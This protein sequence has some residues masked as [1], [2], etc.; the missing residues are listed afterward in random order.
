MT[1]PAD[2]PTEP[3]SAFRADVHSQHGEDGILAELFDRLASTVE[4]S[5]WC[6]EFGAWDGLHLS[7]TANLILHRG[8]RAVLIEPVAERCA[9]ITR[10]L[11]ADRVNALCASV[12]LDP[13]HRLDDLLVGT[14]VPEDLDLLS[15]DIDGDDL[16]VF[17]T[18]RRH[19]PKVVCIEYNFTIPND[20]HYEQPLG[21][22]VAHGSSASAILEASGPLG[23]VLAAVTDSNLVLVRSDLADAVL[24][25][26]RPTLEELRDD[27]DAR[28]YLFSGYDGTLLT[29]APVELPWHHVSVRPSDLQV[30][31]ARLRRFPGNTSRRQR[32]AM[33]AWLAVH[34]RAEFRRWWAVRWSVRTARFRRVPG[35]SADGAT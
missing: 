18:V 8:W 12:G 31:P 21:A 19:R 13:P 10:N 30:L 14:G 16:H 3:L 20:V 22:G 7:N 17:R 34:D 26:S 29:S 33:V 9:E 11:P 6:V 25:P 23:Y 32:L 5:G 1:T 4:L 35:R 15:I 24:G 27:G 28:C 2:R